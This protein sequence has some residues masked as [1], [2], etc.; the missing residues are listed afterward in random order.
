MTNSSIHAIEILQII[1]LIRTPHQK[2]ANHEINRARAAESIPSEYQIKLAANE[3]GVSIANEAIAKVR[4]E[5]IN[6]IR[7][8]RRLANLGYFE[9]TARHFE[10]ALKNILENKALSGKL[11]QPMQRLREITRKKRETTIRPKYSPAETEIR[12]AIALYLRKGE[13]D[14]QFEE[15]LREWK[16]K[17][18]PLN[19]RERRVWRTLEKPLVRK[20]VIQRLQRPRK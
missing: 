15:L 18:A 13:A 16:S 17:R 8:P 6:G 11:S 20:R 5:M 1:Q 4:S 14:P 19:E 2:A 9:E 3:I 10:T 7:D 12:N